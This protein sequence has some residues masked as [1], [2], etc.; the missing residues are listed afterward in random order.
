[1]SDDAGAWSDTPPDEQ[2]GSSREMLARIRWGFVGFVAVS[3]VVIVLAAQNT[4]TVRVK[5]FW[6]ESTAPLI[7]VIL[8]TILATVVL[9]Q[10]VGVIVRSRR[11][12][13]DAEREELRQYRGE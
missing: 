1:M 2:K 9:D 12:K 4:Q 3:I 11:R 10:L 8:V 7:V 13:R 5:A 6:W